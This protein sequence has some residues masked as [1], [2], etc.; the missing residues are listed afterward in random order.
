MGKFDSIKKKPLIIA[1]IV[2]VA[3][4]AV[5]V[6]VKGGGGKKGGGPGGPGGFAQT[7]S[8]RTW[9]AEKTNFDVTV[10]AVGTLEADQEVL[11]SSDVSAKLTKL[12]KDE[13]SVVE[14]G[15]ALLILDEDRFLLEVKRKDGEF[16]K[17]E[18]DAAFAVKN[19]ERNKELLKDGMVT[20]SKYDEALNLK[21]SA[22]GNLDSKRAELSIAKKNF[23]DSRV[24]AP[25][26]GILAERY[27]TVGAYVTQ[28]SKLF[29]LID[30]NPMKVTASIPERYVN[31]VKA[32]QQARLTVNSIEGT[33][34]GKVYFTGPSVDVSTRT[35][36][37]KAE[38]DNSKGLLKP[39][40]FAELSIST[41]TLEGVFLVTENAI[42]MKE[43]KD[44]VFVVKGE[45]V[46]ER[47]VT[48]GDRVE[49]KVV[50]T[51]GVLDGEE[52]VVDGAQNLSTGAKVKAAGAAA[53]PKH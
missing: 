7:Y 18:A 26:S 51:G 31:A 36:T 46:E 23:D 20:Q 30:S 24:K 34:E 22:V 39:G 40:L 29:K 27:V 45:N 1:L 37:V 48:L 53:P 10:K 49:G 41:G 9:K 11:V 38:I 52:I 16:K 43:S 12:V 25:F 47:V 44:V 17:A 13:G 50:I 6:I 15:E 21:N 19:Y 3:L 14:K 8:V 28:G 32:G 4:A 5:V 2:I 35:F 33:F 42:V